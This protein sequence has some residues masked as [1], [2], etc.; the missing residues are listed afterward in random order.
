MAKTLEIT[1]EHDWQL[2][3]AWEMLGETAYFY[4]DNGGDPDGNAWLPAHPVTAD[5]GAEVLEAG[6]GR[7]VEV[8][9]ANNDAMLRVLGFAPLADD[10]DISKDLDDL[11]REAADEKLT[12]WARYDS[13]QWVYIK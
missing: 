1:V 12:K 13:C 11:M 10:E 9:Y 2:K 5:E 4:G 6:Y 7:M 8:L 3:E